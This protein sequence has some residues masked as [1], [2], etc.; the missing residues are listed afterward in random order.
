[1]NH[2]FPPKDLGKSMRTSYQST[3]IELK[4]ESIPAIS[5]TP[6]INVE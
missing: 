1:M 4:V 3:K 2:F 5:N 6:I